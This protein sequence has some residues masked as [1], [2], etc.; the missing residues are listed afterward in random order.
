MLL[1]GTEHALL[2]S[3]N[4]G[5]D[6]AQLPGVPTT[7]YDDLVIHPRDK[8]LVMGTHGR[9]IWILDDTAPIAAWNADAASAPLHLFPIRMATIFHYWKDTSYRGTDQFHGE[10]PADGALIT[11]RVGAANAGEAILT[12]QAADGRVVRRM[13]V[14]AEAGVHRVNWDLRHG[15][16]SDGEGE[17]EVWEL[18]GTER[19]PRNVD[20]TGPFVRPGVYTVVVAAGGEERRAD[21]HVRLDPEMADRITET[22]LRDRERYLLELLDLQQ[23]VQAALESPDESQRARSAEL[24]RLRGRAGQLY[25]ALNG[26][27]VRQGSLYPPTEDMRAAKRAI[28]VRVAALL[29]GARE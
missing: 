4:A 20:S 7:A 22:Q 23:R 26:G 16:P 28:E 5:G 6:W 12:V 18:K 13:Q 24:R 9:S 1:V 14:P 27:G 11:Y 2:V 10:N 19:V 25:N 8:D 15:L 21:V 17:V 3:T 29:E